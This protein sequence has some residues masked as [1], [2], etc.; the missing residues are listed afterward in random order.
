[1]K[2]RRMIWSIRKSIIFS[3]ME[4]YGSYNMDLRKRMYNVY[5]H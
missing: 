2:N 3:N 5:E 4:L 1:M